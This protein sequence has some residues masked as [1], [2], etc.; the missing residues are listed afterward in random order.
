MV[1][2]V[3]VVDG[4]AIMTVMDI[5]TFVDV[6]A[7]MSV[8]HGYGVPVGVVTITVVADGMGAPICMIVFPS[9]ESRHARPIQIQ[10][11]VAGPEII[12]L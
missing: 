4:M 11:H 1:V 2:I 10:P 9:V 5:V 7:L 12:I 6:A 8:P 3:T